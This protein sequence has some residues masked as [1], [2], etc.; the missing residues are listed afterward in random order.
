[1]FSSKEMSV[2]E[3]HILLHYALYALCNMCNICNIC[4]TCTICT[5]C[6]VQYMQYMHWQKMSLCAVHI[7]PSSF[8]ARTTSTLVDADVRA[9][10]MVI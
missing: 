8:F 4:T 2:C 7:L 10:L 9:A 1:M 6:T 5:I 3:G